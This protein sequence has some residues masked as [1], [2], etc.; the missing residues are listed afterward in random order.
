[1]GPCLLRGVGIFSQGKISDSPDPKCP[2]RKHRCST[3]ANHSGLLPLS[4]GHVLGGCERG[5]ANARRSPCRATVSGGDPITI[6]RG[7]DALPCPPLCAYVADTSTSG[8]DETI[9]ISEA[10]D[11]PHTNPESSSTV[12]S[13]VRWCSGTV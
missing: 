12:R 4:P 5:C 3:I 6:Q 13:E 11:L 7:G 1:M 10:I 9:R 8:S 2:E